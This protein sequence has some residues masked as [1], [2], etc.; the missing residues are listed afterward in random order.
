M[1][2]HNTILLT[3]AFFLGLSA[4]LLAQI[5]HESADVAVVANADVP[6]DN[7]SIFEVRHI[8]R[9][10]KQYWK[11]NLKVVLLVPPQGAHERDV[12][13]NVVYRMSESEYKQY[14]I[15]RIFRA[16]AISAPKTAESSATA[17]NLVTRLS[18]CITLMNAADVRSSDRILKIDGKVPGEKGYALR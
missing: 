10:E 3:L 17:K 18:G 12:M 14:W 4:L 8:F 9:G 7:L 6:V 15:G 13:L 1:R 2:L 5:R 16:E 11:S